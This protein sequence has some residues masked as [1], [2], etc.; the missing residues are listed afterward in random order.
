MIFHETKIEGA[1]WI[2]PEPHHDERGF[3]ARTWCR[4]QAREHDID[5]DWVQCNLSHNLRR[6]TLRGMHYQYPNFEAK[7]VRVE[8][9]AIFDAIV[10]IRPD[11]PTYLQSFGL[12]LDAQKCCALFIPAGCAHGFVSLDDQTRIFYQM[13]EYYR[14]DQGHGF[15]YADPQFG[16]E[17]PLDD[18]RLDPAVGPTMNDRDR[19]LAVYSP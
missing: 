13:S 4:R 8:S 7:L 18:L 16:I 3:F 2:E 6:G 17:W 15:H 12:C 1:F 5:V 11:S 10:D 19:N 9:G 14:P